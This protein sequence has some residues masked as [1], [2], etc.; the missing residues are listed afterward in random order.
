MNR[1]APIE[2]IES[3]ARKESFLPSTFSGM[4]RHRSTT[5]FSL[6]FSPRKCCFPLSPTVIDCNGRRT[7]GCVSLPSACLLAC[8]LVG[9]MKRCGI[10]SM[11]SIY[12]RLVWL[13]LEV[14]DECLVFSMFDFFSYEN[15]QSWNRSAFCNT[16]FFSKLIF[17]YAKWS[18]V[19]QL[20]CALESES[21]YFG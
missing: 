6:T 15:C 17:R 10:M 14:I 11:K 16:I 5:E 8:S 1:N 13:I 20:E 2:R 3:I 21:N 18:R 9:G 7:F 19:A 4:G 12:Y